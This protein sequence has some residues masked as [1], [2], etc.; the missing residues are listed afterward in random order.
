MYTPLQKVD[1][2]AI[3]QAGVKFADSAKEFREKSANPP[4]LKKRIA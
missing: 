2:G 1:D 3:K 4:E